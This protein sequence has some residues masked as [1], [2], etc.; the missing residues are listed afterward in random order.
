MISNLIFARAFNPG[1]SFLTNPVVSGIASIGEV[2][3][4]VYSGG[5]GSVVTTQWYRGASPISGAT[6]VNYTVVLADQGEVLSAKVTL[7]RGGRTA[8]AYSNS[9]EIF[10]DLYISEATGDFAND[11]SSE[12]EA[13]T[14][15]KFITLTLT[16]RTNI[17]F[18]SAEEYYLGDIV[19]PTTEASGGIT[20]GAYGSGAKPKIYGSQPIS[21]SWTNTGGGIYS[22]SMA[23]APLWVYLD[24]VAQKL[25][26]S[27]WIPS[28]SYVSTTVIRGSSVTLNAFSSLVGAKIRVFGVNWIVGDEF[29]INA[30][31]SGT[32]NITLSGN[33]HNYGTPTISG[34]K[35]II[36]NQLQ[37]LTDNNEWYYDSGTTTLYYK[38]SVDPSTLDLRAGYKD[39]GFILDG[40]NYDVSGIEMLHYNHAMK[41]SASPISNST[42]DNVKF[43]DC[44]SR[45]LLFAGGDSNS[46][47]N[48]EFRRCG[49]NAGY[50]NGTNS[51]VENNVLDSIGMNFQYPFGFASAFVNNGAGSI[52]RR[53]TINNCA[54][55]GLSSVSTNF[56]IEKNVI[57]NS[58][59]RIRDGGAIYVAGVFGGAASTGTIQNNFCYSMSTTVENSLSSERAMGIYVDHTCN[60]VKVKY[61]SIEGGDACILI[62]FNTQ[63]SQVINNFAVGGIEHELLFRE[64]TSGGVSPLYPNNIACVAEDNILASRASVPC[65]EMRQGNGVTT[66]NP[67]S[68]G[69]NADRNHYVQPYGTNIGRYRATEAGSP[70]DYTLAGWKTKM[71]NDDISSE[72][73]NYIT[74]SNAAN[75][76]VEVAIEMNPTAAAVN[77]NVPAG[78]SDYEGNAFS[79]PVSIPAYNSLIYFKD[80]AA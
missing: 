15:A 7:T 23:S 64:N 51:L 74:F 44:I 57:T 16:D 31:D 25:A 28:T 40:Y 29:T 47:I 26:S 13:I 38:S 50:M 52:S 48:S 80:T 34:G 77:F 71:A 2:L 66:F 78:Y 11:G 24:G 73:T 65:I 39:N 61:N 3:S 42:L 9:I 5:S 60:A 76:I 43:T 17:L 70:T 19:C 30:Y 20:I 53:N 6:S 72:R 22:I 32:G 8:V 56:L 49:D 27:D 4:V 41:A 21:G 54:Y 10:T 35:F 62:N 55:N 67:Y 63:A 37:H 12:A 36:Y 68:S 75:A 58:M 59:K 18:R 69:G 14:V 46:I 33:Y 79:N 1:P 45:G